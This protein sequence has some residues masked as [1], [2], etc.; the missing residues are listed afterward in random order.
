MTSDAAVTSS[1]DVLGMP[2]LHLRACDST[3][4]RARDLAEAGAPHGTLVTAGEQRAGRGRQGRTWSAPAGTALLC[5]LVLRSPPPLL[6]LIAGLAVADVARA[7]LAGA[8]AAGAESA[9]VGAARVGAVGVGAAGVE[10]MVKWPNDVLVGGRKVAGILVE[11]RPQHDWAV[12]GVGINVAMRPDDLPEEVRASA[13]TLGRG[14]AAIE[15]VLEELLD[16]LGVWLAAPTAAIL[17]ALRERDALRG[18][19]VRWGGGA[20]I[21]A[22]I[23]ERGRLL[24]ADDAGRRLALEIGEVHLREAGSS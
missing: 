22:G 21:G 20:G 6:S 3:N 9:G 7:E 23:D 15:P 2:R 14:P 1:A 4:L 8:G 17:E 16:R 13:G 19:P 12:L 5:S 11:A 18:R 24:V 10:A